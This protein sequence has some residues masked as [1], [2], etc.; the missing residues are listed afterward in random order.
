ML[1]RLIITFYAH[2]PNWLHLSSQCWR[3]LRLS[4]FQTASLFHF[5]ATSTSLYYPATKCPDSQKLPVNQKY[6]A[7][8]PQV[9]NVNLF[10][11]VVLEGVCLHPFHNR[12]SA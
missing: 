9:I 8:V 3:A 2:A 6:N 10:L 12:I 7:A 4:T 5:C 1:E 11:D